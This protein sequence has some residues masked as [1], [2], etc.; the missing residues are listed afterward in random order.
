[1][2]LET[3]RLLVYVIVCDRC[4]AEAPPA[5][6]PGEAEIAAVKAGFD[7]PDGAPMLCPAC[8]ARPAPPQ[9]PG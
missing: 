5:L 8:R 3:R 7:L 4:H 1:M 2:P 6:H 9:K